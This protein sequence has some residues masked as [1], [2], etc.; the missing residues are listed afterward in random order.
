VR[1]GVN[2]RREFRPDR[3]DARCWVLYRC[4]TTSV[5]MQDSSAAASDPWLNSMGLPLLVLVSASV[6]MDATAVS[7]SVPLVLN[8]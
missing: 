6:R 1:H 5:T 8:R 7:S 2:T 4:A 3:S